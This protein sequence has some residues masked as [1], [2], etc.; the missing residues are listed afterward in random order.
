MLEA[1]RVGRETANSPEARKRHAITARK[2]ALAQHV[3]KASDQPQ[4]LTPGLFMQRIQPLLANT[5]MSDIRKALGVSK[6]YA[7]KIRQGYRP[8]PRRWRPLA[9]LVG[10]SGTASNCLLISLAIGAPKHTKM[11][12]AANKRTYLLDQA[13]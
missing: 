5:R 1:A 11:Q 9:E 12:H 10:I 2:N 13:N 3:W 6:W 4:W 8:H 7:S